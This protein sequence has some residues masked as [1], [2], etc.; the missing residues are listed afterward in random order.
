[1]GRVMFVPWKPWGGVALRGYGRPRCANRRCPFFVCGARKTA[2]SREFRL[3]RSDLPC[4]LPF[5]ENEG[6][7]CSSPSL[8]D[9]KHAR[10]WLAAIDVHVVTVFLAHWYWFGRFTRGPRV[11]GPHGGGH[12]HADPIPL[13]LPSA[14]NESPCPNKTMLPPARLP[15][16]PGVKDPPG[17][18]NPQASLAR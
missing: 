7:S 12:P 18:S 6:R 1:M 17:V 5:S 16:A 3:F 10:Y 15:A 9:C 8:G 13:R 4:R 2:H 11:E 14:N